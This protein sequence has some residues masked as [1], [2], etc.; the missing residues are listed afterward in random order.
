METDSNAPADIWAGDGLER[1]TGTRRYEGCI[2]SRTSKDIKLDISML[3]LCSRKLIHGL[4]VYLKGK[5]KTY[6]QRKAK[7]NGKTADIRKTM[8]CVSVFLGDLLTNCQ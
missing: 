2:V 6:I 1:D 8:N 5:N 3:S 7:R 4:I